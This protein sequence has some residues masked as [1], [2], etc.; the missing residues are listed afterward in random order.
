MIDKPAWEGDGVNPL[1]PP[2][3]EPGDRLRRPEGGFK[4][5]RDIGT[6]LFPATLVDQNRLIAEK[7]GMATNSGIWSLRSS[8]PESSAVSSSLDSRNR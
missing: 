7:R 4:G 5:G 8:A 1:H 6:Q 3:G 2:R